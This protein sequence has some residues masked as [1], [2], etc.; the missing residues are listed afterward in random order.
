MK[1]N[2]LRIGNTVHVPQTKQDATISVIHEH[3]GVCVN[4][5]ILVVLSFNDIEPIPLTEE[6][7][8]KFGFNNDGE[9]PW[10]ISIG[11]Y[12]DRAWNVYLMGKHCEK[13]GHIRRL[14]SVHQLQNLYFA[15]T[16]Q[17]LEIK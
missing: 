4:N 6:W 8:L 9:D 10:E 3:L 14:S 17:E 1:A 7:L 5:N 11:R 16:G 2:E 12:D 15:L 13:L